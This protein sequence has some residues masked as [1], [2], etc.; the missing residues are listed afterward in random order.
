MKK[1]EKAVAG[2]KQD[3]YEELSAL[4]SVA[5]IADDQDFSVFLSTIDE[6]PGEVKFTAYAIL[7]KYYASPDG[8]ILKAAA[9]VIDNSDGLYDLVCDLIG[10]SR[11]D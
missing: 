6:L 3:L 1:R 8:L 2:L 10:A 4:Q 9:E 5:T 11:R 7:D